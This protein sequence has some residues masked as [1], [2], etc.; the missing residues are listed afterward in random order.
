MKCIFSF[1]AQCQF[2]MVPKNF[3]HFGF[4]HGAKPLGTTPTAFL[5]RYIS[6]ALL[7]AC[8]HARYLARCQLYKSVSREISSFWHSA[9][10]SGLGR[11][12]I[13]RSLRSREPKGRGIEARA[14]V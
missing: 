8:Q 3:Y 2:G 4:W 14:R 1:L 7:A 12:P 11:G 5:N 13:F 9:N 6:H 10:S